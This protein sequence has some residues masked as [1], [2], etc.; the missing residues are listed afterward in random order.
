MTIMFIMTLQVEERRMT[1]TMRLSIRLPEM[2]HFPKHNHH[3]LPR[4]NGGD[5]TL[6]TLMPTPV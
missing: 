1:V 6:M 4:D 3:H 5:M 2:D